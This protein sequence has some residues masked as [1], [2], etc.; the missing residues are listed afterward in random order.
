MTCRA[1]PTGEPDVYHAAG[2]TVDEQKYDLRGAPQRQIVILRSTGVY[3]LEKP[4][5]MVR[6]DSGSV[7]ETVVLTTYVEGNALL[8]AK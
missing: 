4:K 3:K 2:S 7:R 8:M 6:I 5:R 1:L